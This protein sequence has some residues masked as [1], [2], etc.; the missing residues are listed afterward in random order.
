[1]INLLKKRE[2][3]HNQGK[4]TVKEKIIFVFTNKGKTLFAIQNGTPVSTASKI[5]QEQFC[6]IKFEVKHQ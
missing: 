1:M 2:V 6:D 5:Y 3:F 4:S